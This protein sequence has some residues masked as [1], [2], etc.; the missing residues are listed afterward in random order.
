MSMN[1]PLA[2]ITVAPILCVSMC[3]E[4]TDVSVAVAMNLQMTSTLVSVSIKI[5]FPSTK[6]ILNPA[7]GFPYV[8]ILAVQRVYSVSFL[9]M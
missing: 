4:V 9:K 7:L 3:W 2:F 5:S 1:V 8:S 6:K